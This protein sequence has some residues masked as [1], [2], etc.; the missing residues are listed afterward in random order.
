[1]ED[2]KTDA[3]SKVPL[4]GDI[5]GLGLLFQRKVTVKTKTELLIFLTP[6]VAK[7]PENLEPMGRDEQAGA[8]IVPEAVGPGVFQ[9]HMAGMQ[10]GAASQP[11][12][13][14]PQSQPT[15]WKIKVNSP[16]K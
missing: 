7:E 14:T 13:Q 16:Q 6:H 11:A 12:E 8:K 1:M 2:R 10:R 5:P 4:L 15:K 9:E 3:V